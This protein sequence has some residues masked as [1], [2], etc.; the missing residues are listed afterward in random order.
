MKTRIQ[1]LAT[2]M[3]ITFFSS[4]GVK[5]SAETASIYGNWELEKAI[6][7]CPFTDETDFSGNTLEIQSNQIDINSPKN[8][9]FIKPTGEYTFSTQDNYLKIG[10]TVEYSYEIKD[11]KLIIKFLE[12]P[13]LADDELTLIYKPVSGK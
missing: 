5:K 12:E 4:C 2:A 10:E 7:F 3:I 13:E 1:L 6:C 8:M 9:Q 11:G